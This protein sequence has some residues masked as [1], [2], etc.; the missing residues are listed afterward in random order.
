MR[1]ETRQGSWQGRV[2][3]LCVAVEGSHDAEQPL[4]DGQGLF[5]VEQK[6]NR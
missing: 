2:C 6:R 3:R 4:T 5:H 1:S